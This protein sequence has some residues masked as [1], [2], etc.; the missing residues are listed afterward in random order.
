M[1]LVEVNKHDS[2]FC[3]VLKV[4]DAHKDYTIVFTKKINNLE[5]LKEVNEVNYEKTN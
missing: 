3:K 2:F 1:L 4:V 5:V